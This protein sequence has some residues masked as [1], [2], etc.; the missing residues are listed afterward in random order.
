MQI[1]L[2]IVHTAFRQDA[3]FVPLEKKN[4]N[5]KTTGFFTYILMNKAHVE[6]VF[7]TS[8]SEKLMILQYLFTHETSSC[9]QQI[10][11]ERTKQ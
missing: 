6:G 10:P 9:F 4:N 7:S 5:K 1:A 3:F 2:E 11:S 8:K